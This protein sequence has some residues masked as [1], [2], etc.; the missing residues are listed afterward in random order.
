MTANGDKTV[1]QSLVDQFWFL[2][3]RPGV[4][5]G[6]MDSFFKER[7]IDRPQ[8]KTQQDERDNFDGMEI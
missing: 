5:K 2:T 3:K 4:N 8:T 7:K 1:A 6:T